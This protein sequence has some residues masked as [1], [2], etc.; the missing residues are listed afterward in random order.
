MAQTTLHNRTDV[1]DFLT[2]QHQRIKALFDETLLAAGAE[3]DESFVRLRRLLAV[4]ETA[5]EEIVH[6][7]AAR[8]LDHGGEVIGAR[9]EEEKQA[10]T[11][12]AHLEDVD[13]DSEFFT[14]KLRELRDDVVDHAEH[15]EREEFSG[16]RAELSDDELQRLER[17]VRLAEAIAPTRPHAGV[18]GALANALVGPFASMM[19]RA[20]DAI[21]GYDS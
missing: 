1:V 13:V 11:V 8:E 2:E 7:R 18:E 10:K 20:R 15:E 19:D 4:H 17:A 14:E 21:L 12:L 6:P 5:E 9:L 3:R 16:L